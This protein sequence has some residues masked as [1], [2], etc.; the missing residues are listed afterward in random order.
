M[1]GKNRKRGDFAGDF[2]TPRQKYLTPATFPYSSLSLSA[3]LNLG[4]DFVVVI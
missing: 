3:L 2:A 4:V 1:K